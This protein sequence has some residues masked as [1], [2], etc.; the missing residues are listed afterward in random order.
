MQ[1]KRSS[2]TKREELTRGVSRVSQKILKAK[3]L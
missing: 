1:F 2:V 3:N